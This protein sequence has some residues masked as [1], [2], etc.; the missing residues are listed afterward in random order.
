ME[1]LIILFIMLVYVLL[2]VVFVKFVQRRTA[3]RTYRRLALAFV[4]LL[5]TWDAFLGF[6]V[7]YPAHLSKI[8]FSN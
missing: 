8:G 1:V 6:I 5:P 2:S 7:Y 4:I 3:N